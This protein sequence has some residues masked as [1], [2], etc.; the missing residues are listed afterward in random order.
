LIINLNLAINKFIRG[1]IMNKPIEIHST[2]RD[3]TGKNA[4][5]K[6]RSNGCIPAVVYGHNFSTI[7]LSVKE[8]EING[9]FA[10]GQ[11]S[12]GEYHLYKLIIDDMPAQD[13]VVIFKEIQRHP[14][15][16]SFKHI[17]FFAVKM[18]EKIHTAVQ[19]TLNGKAEGVKLGGILRQ[20]LREIDVEG[21]PAEIPSH[22]ELDVSELLIG[23][24]LLV[25]D[26]KIPA[27]IHVLID[28]EAPV[29]NVLPPTVLKAEETDEAE[30]DEEAAETT[31]DEAQTEEKTDEQTSKETVDKK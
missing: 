6:L 12:S 31:V 29:V 26:L 30:E 20:I 2:T 8:S 22:F 3:K 16:G 11:Q 15:T 23:D 25:S 1:K 24:S 21:L 28:P 4:A 7:P 18:D 27:N 9:I 14:L 19:I 17:D 5:R 13:T 10:A